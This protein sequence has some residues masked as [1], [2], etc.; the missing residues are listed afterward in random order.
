MKK[1]FIL[2][3]ALFVMA[4]VSAQTRK[5]GDI[6]M[7]GGEFGVVFAVTTDGQHGKA[8]SV[9]QTKCNLND[10]KA[11]CANLGRGWKLPTKDEL[12]IIYRKKSAINSVLSTNGYTQLMGFYWSSEASSEFCAWLV[13]MLNG[14]TLS[15]G[16]YFYHY[17]RAVSAF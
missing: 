6:V 17:V 14:N 13:G 1:I 8:V 7:V 12:L 5:V 2:I 11:W 15:D 3:C 4:N 9:S 16:K 10:A